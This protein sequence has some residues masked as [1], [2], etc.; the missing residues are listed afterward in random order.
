MTCII[1]VEHNGKAWIGADGCT[2]LVSNNIDMA[3]ESYSSKIVK[4]SNG[5]LIGCAG[6]TIAGNLLRYKFDCPEIT[7]GELWDKYIYST[8]LDKLKSCLKDYV[9]GDNFSAI[10]S[11]YGKMYCV[12]NDFHILHPP[13]YGVFAIGSGSNIAFGAMY[14]FFETYNN[15]SFYTNIKGNISYALEVVSFFDNN[16]APP[17]DIRYTEALTNK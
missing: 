12:C 3:F 11:W 1:G 13:K 4:L 6:D 14:G 8:F 2:T 16:V 9:D 5:M 17:F 7:E 10:I 15:P